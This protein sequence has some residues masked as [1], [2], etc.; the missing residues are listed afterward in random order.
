MEDHEARK[1]LDPLKRG[2]ELGTKDKQ[3]WET[4]V[5]DD[6]KTVHVATDVGQGSS[7]HCLRQ[8]GLQVYFAFITSKY[9]AIGDVVL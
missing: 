3:Q 6:V 8:L 1:R 5:A 4:T 9:F 7:R 2:R